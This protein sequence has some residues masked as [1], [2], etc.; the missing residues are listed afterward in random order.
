METTKT[1]SLCPEPCMLH[2]EANGKNSS[3][4]DE[5]AKHCGAHTG[6]ASY[7]VAASPVTY[8]RPARHISFLGRKSRYNSG[9]G[10]RSFLFA[11]HISR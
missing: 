8:R 11:R 7:S 2:S 6:E 9:C 10:L 3:H 5:G 4:A 1:N